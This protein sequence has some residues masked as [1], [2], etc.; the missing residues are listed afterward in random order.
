MIRRVIA[1]LFAATLIM[2]VTA[3]G[4][5][6]AKTTTQKIEFHLEDGYYDTLDPATGEWIR[7]LASAF[8]IGNIKDTDKSQCLSPLTGAIAIDGIKHQI[9]VKQ[10]KQSEPVYYYEFEEG[11]QGSDFYEKG[12]VWSTIV[13]V[14]IEGDKYIGSLSWEK[15]HGEW[16]GQVVDYENSQL[17]FQSFVDG[18]RVFCA[19]I[20]DFPEIG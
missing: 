15:Y 7:V 11:T 20:G 2:S 1:V 16:Y 18:K 4:M 5:A 12:Q 13:E 6:A 10:P 8:L 3:I 19:V 9:L 14:N 17:Y